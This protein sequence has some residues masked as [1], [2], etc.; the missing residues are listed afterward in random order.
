MKRSEKKAL[1][2]HIGEFLNVDHAR[3]SDDEAQ[4]LGN[5]ID[6]Y[7][8]DY[9]GNSTTKHD[10]F[11]GWSSDGRYTRNETTTYTFMDEP[12]IREDYSYRDDDGQ[13]GG[14]TREITDARGILD[15]FKK[16]QA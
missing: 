7:D 9:R 16:H 3:M 14:Y 12:G 6:S 1:R 8:T 15:W 4:F 10:S 2:G 5:F 13:T 11:D